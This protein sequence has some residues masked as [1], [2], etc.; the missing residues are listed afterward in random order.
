MNYCVAPSFEGKPFLCD[1]YERDGKMYVKI[2]NAS[3]GEREIR[4]YDKPQAAWSKTKKANEAEKAKAPKAKA[5][6]AKKP[7]GKK[8]K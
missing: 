6:S 8:R 7:N 1:P 4:I 5:K 2:K 3:G